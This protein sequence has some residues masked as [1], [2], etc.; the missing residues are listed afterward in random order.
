[1]VG[2]F[3]GDKYPKKTGTTIAIWVTG[4]ISFGF[5]ALF[6]LLHPAEGSKT[7]NWIFGALAVFSGL[8]IFLFLVV[9]TWQTRRLIRFK[10]GPVINFETSQFGYIACLILFGLI[11]IVIVSYGAHLILLA[12]R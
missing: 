5:F 11:S 9:E 10:G 12:I 6:L 4:A 1:M 7:S 2:G 8:S 3:Y